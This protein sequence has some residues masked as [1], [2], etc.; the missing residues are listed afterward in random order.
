MK[1]QCFRSLEHA[2]STT[3]ISYMGLCIAMLHFFLLSTFFYFF[4]HT[5]SRHNIHSK[6]TKQN[7]RHILNILKVQSKGRKRGREKEKTK[8]VIPLYNHVC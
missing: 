6:Q 1:H 8:Q 2:Y 3:L 4:L 5:T 7:N